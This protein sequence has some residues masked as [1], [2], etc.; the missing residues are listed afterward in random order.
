MGM[1]M[2]ATGNI[3][4]EWYG[5]KRG[6]VRSVFEPVPSGIIDSALGATPLAL[7]R[8]QFLRDIIDL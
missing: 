3:S 5:L 7:G 8:Y 4:Q 2:H 1:S 6:P